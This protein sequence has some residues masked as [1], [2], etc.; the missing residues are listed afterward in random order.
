MSVVELLSL[1]QEHSISDLAEHSLRTLITQPERLTIEE[2]RKLG[3]EL[4]MFISGLREEMLA[5]NMCSHGCVAC[6][7]KSHGEG[8]NTDSEF[9]ECKVKEWVNSEK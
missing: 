9:M 6:V 8:Q 2:G 7:S 5:R 3:V 4:V 1:A